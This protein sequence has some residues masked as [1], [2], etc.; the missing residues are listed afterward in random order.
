V[1]EEGRRREKM[2][3]K[4]KG[5]RKEKK[6]IGKKFKPKKFLGR[7]IKD[8]WFITPRDAAVFQNIFLCEFIFISKLL[9]L[10]CPG[11]VS[12]LSQ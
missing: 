2:K 7:K 8:N 1:Q 5:K 12:N 6:K 9:L 4:R 11:S 10:V 3:K